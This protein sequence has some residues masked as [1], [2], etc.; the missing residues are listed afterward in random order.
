MLLE[1]K[2][3]Y[4]DVFIMLGFKYLLLQEFARSRI[5][6]SLCLQARS[7]V[8]CPGFR[9]HLSEG[10][11]NR[12]SKYPLFCHSAE[13]QGYLRLFTQ[14]KF[15]TTGSP[16][17][18]WPMPPLRQ[19]CRGLC[20]SYKRNHKICKCICYRWG[21]QNPGTLNYSSGRLQS[22]QVTVLIHIPCF[23]CSCPSS[24]RDAPR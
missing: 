17:P 7:Y 24:C 1:K 8:N 12:G 2:I 5:M 13:S 11:W 3:S 16:L 18:A 15:I 19:I 21:N 10:H 20:L 4:I 22:W 6:A 23:L 14:S 9:T